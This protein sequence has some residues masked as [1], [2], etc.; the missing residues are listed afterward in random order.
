MAQSVCEIMSIRQLL[1]EVGIK[2]SVPAKVWC[3][4]QAAM[5]I[6]SNPVFH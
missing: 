2:T 1:T 5:H 4:N 6:A 3:D